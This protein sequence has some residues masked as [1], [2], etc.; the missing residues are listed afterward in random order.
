MVLQLKHFKFCV[1]NKNKRNAFEDGVHKVLDLELEH[2]KTVESTAVMQL[3]IMKNFL[4]CNQI[5]SQYLTCLV[6][7]PEH[8][9]FELLGQV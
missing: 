8:T 2:Y 1:R 4:H 7:G 9:G 6:L 5:S 3:T